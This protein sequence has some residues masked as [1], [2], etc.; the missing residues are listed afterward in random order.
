[1]QMGRITILGLFQ[2]SVA[3]AEADL[4]AYGGDEMKRDEKRWEKKRRDF[5]AGKQPPTLNN[6]DESGP[7]AP[8][9]GETKI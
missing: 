8:I 2:D 9:R 5:C 3:V 4:L 6:R 7:G 1:M